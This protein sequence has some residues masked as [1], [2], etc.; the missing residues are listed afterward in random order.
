MEFHLNEALTNL[1]VGLH[2]ELRGER[3]TAMRFIQVY[4][5]D[6][7]LALVRLTSETSL[8]QPDPF[9][10]TRRVELSEAHRALPLDEMVG[11]L[12]HNAESAAAI[13]HWLTTHHPADPVIVA[14]V[15]QL[16]AAALS[17]EQDPGSLP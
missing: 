15:E 12:A 1:F 17:Q 3:L 16:I 7:V 4:A 10:P 9:D 6:H 5:V 13:L 11:G 2:R 8:A 14:A